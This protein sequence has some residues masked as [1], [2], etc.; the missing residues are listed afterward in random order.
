VLSVCSAF[1]AEDLLVVQGLSGR[2]GGRLVS[3]ERLEPRTLN[4]IYADDG[5]SKN[6]VQRMMADLI[7]I[8]RLTFKTEPALAKSFQVSPDGLR[9]ELELRQGLKFSDGHP[10]DADDVIF[11]FQVCL[12]PEVNSTQR[13][14]WVFDGKPVRVRKL[15][16]YR[17]VS[18]CRGRML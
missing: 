14:L 7:H 10:F 16:Q 1:A 17:V 12:D 4:P 18:K 3:G 6:I 2:P 13:P 11:T 5:A 8:N 15:G 9:Y